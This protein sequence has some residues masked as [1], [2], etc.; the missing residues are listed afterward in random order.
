M[1]GKIEDRRRGRQRMRRLGGVTSA[2]E[3]N[4]GKLQE[5]VRDREAWCVAV[6]G[7]AELD[8]TG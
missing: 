8:M 1:L 3:V 6:H 7:I 2:M 4:L 5:I